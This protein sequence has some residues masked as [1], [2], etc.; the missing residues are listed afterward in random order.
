MEIE[1][2][3]SADKEL[4]FVIMPFGGISDLYYEKIYAPA[5]KDAGFEPK[6]ADEIYSSGKIIDDIWKYTK[7]A[8]FI[9]ADLTDRNPNVLYEL[10]LAHAIGK[11]AIL[12]TESATDIPF[13]LRALRH[14]IYDKNIPDWG[15]RLRIAI[16]SSVKSLMASPHESVLPIFLEIEDIP[17]KPSLTKYELNLLDVKSSIESLRSEIQTSKLIPKYEELFVK[18]KAISKMVEGGLDGKL[19]VNRCLRGA[20]SVLSTHMDNYTEKFEVTYSDELP[21]LNGHIFKIEQA[22]VNII[23]NALCSLPERKKGLRI[24]TKYDKEAGQVIIEFVDEGVG[25]SK[26][27]LAQAIQPFYTTWSERGCTGLGLSV[28]YGIIKEH[29]GTIDFASTPGKGTIVTV[30]LPARA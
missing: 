12:I 7:K 21:I 20:I 4:C 28:T 22:F 11:Q 3:D 27:V 17:K 5:I 6:R 18:F 19:D 9:F 16:V 25:M 8:K 10:G 1:F 26:E 2:K 29:G 24:A 15:E 23:M 14:I 30:R 13:D